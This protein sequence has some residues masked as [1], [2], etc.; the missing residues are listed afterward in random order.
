M[1][2][3]CSTSER[4][5]LVQNDLA[6]SWAWSR[7]SSH[8]ASEHFGFNFPHR[9]DLL[10]PLSL[11]CT[12][13][14]LLRDSS[15]C[16]HPV[17]PNVE[18]LQFLHLIKSCRFLQDNRELLRNPGAPCSLPALKHRAV[19]ERNSA[20]WLPCF[21][22]QGAGPLLLLTHKHSD[23]YTQTTQFLPKYLVFDS[24]CYV[25][26][27]VLSFCM[28]SFTIHALI[29]QEWLGEADQDW[30]GLISKAVLVKEL[31]SKQLSVC[32]NKK[33]PHLHGT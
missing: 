15:T 25:L 8:A 26:L 3:Y 12:A 27:Q 11:C 2:C 21:L 18:F 29:E 17:L 22:L 7:V 1:H 16:N 4:K 30:T 14:H 19:L 23:S 24:N 33:N 5:H 32:S 6:L 13:L 9:H 28:T 31:L 20:L 10:D